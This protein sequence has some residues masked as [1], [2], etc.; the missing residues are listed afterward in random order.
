VSRDKDEPIPGFDYRPDRT[1]GA[2]GHPVVFTRRQWKELI[3]A[4][5]K[6]GGRAE[7]WKDRDGKQTTTIR[8]LI[9]GRL[10]GA[11]EAYGL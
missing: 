4:I 11:L 8:E 5:E 2:K 3:A 6:A 10:D 1:P 9:N 7:R